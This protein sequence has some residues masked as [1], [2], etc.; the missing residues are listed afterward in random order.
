MRLTEKRGW[1]KEQLSEISGVSYSFISDITNGRGNPSLRTME[2]LAI[3][4]ETPLT[5]L[6]ESTDLE[7]DSLGDTKG[8][9]DGFERVTLVLSNHHA[10]QAKKWAKEDAKKRLKQRM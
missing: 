7:T 1:T 9:P 5:I 8:L 10:F 3:A 6:L 2:K 4:L